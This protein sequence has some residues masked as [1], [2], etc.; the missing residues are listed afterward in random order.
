MPSKT[1]L[2]DFWNIESIGIV[3]KHS[4]SDD[5]IAMEH[6]KE[7]IRYNENRNSVTWP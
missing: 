5:V 3:D 1:E 7:T 6:F 4:T 2:E